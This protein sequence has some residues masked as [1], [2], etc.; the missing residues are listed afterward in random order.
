MDFGEILN[1]WEKKDKKENFKDLVDKYIPEKIEKETF[2]VDRKKEA[3]KRREYLRKLK[4]QKVLDLHG[5]KR[6]NAIAALSSFIINSKKLGLKKVLIIPG[7][8]IH[9]KNGP[10][11]RN[12]VI[13]YLEQNRL[14]GEF[15]SAEREYGG[16]GALWVILR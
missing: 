13:K 2:S 4:P 12:A 7:K 5:F 8:G 3:I 14:T 1:E 9:S 16:K 11:L 10:V 6:D 15:G